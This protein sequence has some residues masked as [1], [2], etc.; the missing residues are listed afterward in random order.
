MTHD[1]AFE[2]NALIVGARMVR[3]RLSNAPIP[4][5]T[6]VSLADAIAASA[7]VEATPGQR[8]PDGSTRL[9]CHVDVSRVP[10]LYAWAVVASQ[11]GG[12]SE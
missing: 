4:D 1:R 5:L 10:R 3:E 9:T 12:T 2:I 11:M 8:Q 6:G 7:I